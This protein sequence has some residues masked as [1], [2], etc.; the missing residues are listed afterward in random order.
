ELLANVAEPQNPSYLHGWPERVRLMQEHWIGKS[1]GVRFAFP[2]HIRGADGKPIQ[3]GKLW[4]FT[5]RADT[6]MGVTF[7][8]VAAEHPL[9]AHAARSNPKLAVFVEECKRGTVIEAELAT[10]EKKGMP[11]GLFVTHPLTGEKIEAWVGNYVLI[12]Y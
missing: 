3:D 10:M 8:A 4:V 6:I 12:A 2:H 1:E 11:T 9:A 5:T 7:C